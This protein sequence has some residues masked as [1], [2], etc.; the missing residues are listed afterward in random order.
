MS[1]KKPFSKIDFFITL[2][3]I[4]AFFGSLLLSEPALFQTGTGSLKA[5][6]CSDS[7][8]GQNRNLKGEVTGK[9]K[10]KPAT[11]ITLKDTCVNE[12]FIDEAVCSGDFAVY[13]RL[14]CQGRCSNGRCVAKGIEGSTCAQDTDCETHLTCSQKSQTCTVCADSDNGKDQVT[15]GSVTFINKET[16][17]KK[18]LTDACTGTSVREWYCDAGT[19]RSTIM[20]CLTGCSEGQCS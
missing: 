8:A 5:K 20:S 19:P 10:N 13:T 12:Q 11:T 14:K 15:K 2:L 1:R 6:I 16:G 9:N 18:Q 3:V 7:D 17:T 4:V